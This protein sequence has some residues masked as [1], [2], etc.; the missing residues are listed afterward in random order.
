[1]SVK[2]LAIGQLVVAIAGRDEGHLYMVVGHQ[3]PTMVLLADGRSRRL[4]NPKRKNV[5][6][7]TLLRAMAKTANHDIA[8]GA[9][10]TDV[11]IRQVLNQ[12]APD[13]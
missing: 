2:A 4:A 1:M 12:F 5:R 3:T 9:Q 11:M 6:H 10:L 13:L 7:L 8:V